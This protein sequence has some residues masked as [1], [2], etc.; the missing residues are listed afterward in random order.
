MIYGIVTI[1]ILQLIQM[2]Q[3][4]KY[5]VIQ[6]SVDV[7]T[8]LVRPPKHLLKPF[9]KKSGKTKPKINDDTSAWKMENKVEFER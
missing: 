4:Y 1:I 8:N 5:N 7:E 2:I 3:T 6:Q 9:A